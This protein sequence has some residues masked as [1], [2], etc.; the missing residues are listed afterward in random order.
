MFKKTTGLAKDVMMRSKK[1][2]LIHLKMKNIIINY[3]AYS[4]NKTKS[5]FKDR[6]ESFMQQ[7]VVK[8]ST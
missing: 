1:G 4:S 6:V 5:D 3:N 8:I 7:T 2:F